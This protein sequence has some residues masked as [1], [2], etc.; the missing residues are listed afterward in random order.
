MHEMICYVCVPGS[1]YLSSHAFLVLLILL[2]LCKN[3]SAHLSCEF[4]H[5]PF[6]PLNTFMWNFWIP[7]H[8]GTTD[9][10]LC[11]SAVCLNRC[12]AVIFWDHSAHYGCSAQTMHSHCR[13]LT[14]CSFVQSLLW[15]NGPVRVV[16]ASCWFMPQSNSLSRVFCHA[17]PIP[18]REEMEPLTLSVCCLSNWSS[19]IKKKFW[20]VIH[21]GRGSAQ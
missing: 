12:N 4:S 17:R 7:P 6:N 11:Q 3:S 13:R 20:S 21:E 2:R 5:V 16:R 19:P 10:L 8:N 1:R 14:Y 18:T 15:R 9:D